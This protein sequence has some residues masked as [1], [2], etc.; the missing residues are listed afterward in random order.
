MNIK[1]DRKIY[2]TETAELVAE[3]AQ[4][5]YGDSTGFE[6]KLYKRGPADYFLYGHGGEL[7]PYPQPALYVLAV[8]DARS[9]MLRVVGEEFA[10]K[11][12]GIVKGTTRK[13]PAVKAEKT[14]AV[15]AAPAVETAK[16]PVAK[17]P[18][19]PAAKK[20][21]PVAE[22]K[23]PAAKDAKVAKATPAVKAPKVAATKAPKAKK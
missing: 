17:A 23:A 12:L 2:N 9:W 7:S 11:E 3:T 15:K 4:G 1:I 19:T 20:T 10:N 5:A 21:A 13:A 22:K 16:T 6:E 8:E 14:A 18:K